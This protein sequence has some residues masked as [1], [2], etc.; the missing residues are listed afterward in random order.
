MAIPTILQLTFFNNTLLQYIIFFS[1]ITGAILIG[2]IAYYLI[3][4]FV[5]VLTK[6][7]QTV[8]D[9]MLIEV[10][11]HPVVFLIFIIGFYIAYKSLTLTEAIEHTF[12]NIVLVMFIF[13]LTW[14]FTRLIDGVIKYYLIPFSQKTQTDLD[15]ALIPILRRMS[16]IILIFIAAIIVLDKFGYNVASLVAG[17]GIGGLAVALAAQET[18]S[19]VFG[20]VTILTDKPF[21]L[22]DRIKVSGN[23]GF[24]KEIG[25]RS[26]K[27]TTLDGSEL[28]V[29]NATIAKE[30]IENVTREKSRRVKLTVGLVY[31]TDLKKLKKAMEIVKKIVVDQEGVEDKCDVFF[32]E[33]AD[34]SLNFVIVYWVTDIPRIFEI[35]SAI[36]LKIKETFEK[37]GLEFAYP[38]R[39]IYNK[40]G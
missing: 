1:I 29:P 36:N 32:D 15:D 31:E 2:K 5:K 19:N 7:T 23:D 30:I 35:K 22:G 20:G 34:F 24:V 9:D 17:L 12:F 4:N 16:K 39:V 10:C 13:N 37:E 33:F 25:M 40:K 14:F 6:K 26:T 18:L 11:E 8:A 21:A 28:V 27:I 38:T 3:K